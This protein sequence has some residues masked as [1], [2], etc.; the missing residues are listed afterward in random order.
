MR[1]I[2]YTNAFV[3]LAVKCMKQVATAIIILLLS[4]KALSCYSPPIYTLEQL[5]NYIEKADTA[6]FGKVVKVEEKGKHKVEW[7]TQSKKRPIVNINYDVQEATYEVE[8]IIKGNVKPVVI[9]QNFLMSSMCAF[10]VGV[11]NEH[12]EPI[13]FVAVIKDEKNPSKS[14]ATP[15]HFKSIESDALDTIKRNAKNI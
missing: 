15:I 8:M 7:K 5:N 2:T 14:W 11:A 4:G 13:F 10:G 6:F 3:E 1:P 12:F 9:E